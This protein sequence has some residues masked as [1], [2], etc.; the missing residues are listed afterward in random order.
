MDHKC[1]S[2]GVVCGRD[3]LLGSTELHWRYGAELLMHRLLRAV[4][5]GGYLLVVG[6]EPYDMVLER[7]P[8][9]QDRLVLDIEALGDTAAALAVSSSLC[10]TLLDPCPA[11]LSKAIVARASRLTGSCRRVGSKARSSARAASAWWPR[12]SSR[13]G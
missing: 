5:P 9:S 3:Y 4:R 10:K 13:C 11:R 2:G 7:T 6:I 12:R 8:G 1:L